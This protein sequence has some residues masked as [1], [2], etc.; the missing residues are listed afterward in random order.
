MEIDTVIA[1]LKAT[2]GIPSD[3]TYH[4]LPVKNMGRVYGFNNTRFDSVCLLVAAGKIRAMLILGNRLVHVPSLG[5]L[6]VKVF[7]NAETLSKE[8][9]SLKRFRN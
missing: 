8:L 3:F 4:T 5:Y 2:K 1:E 7:A 9:N 6:G